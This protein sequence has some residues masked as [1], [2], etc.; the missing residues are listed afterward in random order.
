[1]SAFRPLLLL[2]ATIAIYSENLGLCFFFSL[3]SFI[4]DYIAEGDASLCSEPISY[5]AS[6]LTLVQWP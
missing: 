5:S 6:Y 1:M 4:P 2:T 3:F